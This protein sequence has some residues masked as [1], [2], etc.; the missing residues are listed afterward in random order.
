MNVLQS[1]IVT[2]CEL[3]NN[4]ARDQ[5]VYIIC[6]EKFLNQCMLESRLGF[7]DDVAERVC[8]LCVKMSVCVCM[9][10]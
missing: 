4:G 8:V 10:L 3:L 7:R 6:W 5:C 1:Q 2:A 9:Y